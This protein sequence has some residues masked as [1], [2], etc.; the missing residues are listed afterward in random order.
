MST[1]SNLSR[2]IYVSDNG[3]FAFERC[4]NSYIA[5]FFFFLKFKTA[6]N[7]FI[8]KNVAGAI[9]ADIVPMMDVSVETDTLAVTV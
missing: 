2:N 1:F 4:P 9:L 5:L 8:L 6:I 3:E 7:T